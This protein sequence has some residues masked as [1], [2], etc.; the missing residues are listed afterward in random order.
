MK[1]VLTSKKYTTTI[2]LAL[3]FIASAIVIAPG[4]VSALTVSP[5]RIEIAGDAGKTV[6]GEIELYNEQDTDNT[7]YF[8]YQNFESQ[9]ETGTPN[10]VDGTE[11][12]ATWIKTDD[13]VV[14]KAGEQ[15]KIPF[16]ITVPEGVSPGGYF[17]GI[18]LSTTP[19]A[20]GS[21][22]QVSIGAKV[23]V[24]VLMRVNGAINESADISDF[25]TRDGQKFFTSLPVG[26]T[27]RF[28][29]S[30]GDRIMPD[31]FITIKHIFGWTSAKVPANPER[32]NV[33]PFGSVRKFNASWGN[34]PIVADT[35]HTAFFDAVAHEWKHFA[36]GR[37]T[38]KLDLVYG[39]NNKQANA[40]ISFWVI[41]W[42]LLIV[43]IGGMLILY[44]LLRFIAHKYNHWVIVQAEEMLEHERGYD[45]MPERMK[46]TT[47]A[48]SSIEPESRELRIQSKPKRKAPAKRVVKAPAKKG[49]RLMND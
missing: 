13:S 2:A 33:L 16:S 31:G 39:D 36:F 32:G 34:D 45:R 49:K 8:S 12:L 3:F 10:F 19:P 37:Y 6:T 7:F 4:K 15:K 20:T 41:P 38:A 44:A 21:G 46:P 35:D 5:P 30:G 11:G 48:K 47:R 27:Y 42:H 23:G 22:G 1:N 26:F 9:G 29:N 14:L 25:M 17:A 24:L 18:F 28:Q 40:K 43:I